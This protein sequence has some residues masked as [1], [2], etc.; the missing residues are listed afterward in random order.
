MRRSFRDC[1]GNKI[2][3][4]AYCLQ[5]LLD[6]PGTKIYV[7]TDSQKKSKIV[8]YAV[9]IAFRYPSRGCH[10][11]YYKWSESGKLKGDAL[12]EYR[13]K[14]EIE[15]TME[16]AQRLQDNSIKVYQVDFDLNDDCK[17]KSHQ[18]VQMATGWAKGLGYQVSIK[19]DEQ[20][21]TKAA[22]NLVN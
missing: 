12:I 9:V 19:P 3:D 15:V 14:K 18:F 10:Y 1:E 16:V 2:Q 11:I 22:N 5:T 13:L 17:W 20:V 7:G 6:N 8:K 21:A 4:L